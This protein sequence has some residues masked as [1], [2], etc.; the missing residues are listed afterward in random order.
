MY[1]S[2][3]IFLMASLQVSFKSGLRLGIK[4]FSKQYYANLRLLRVF[5]LRLSAKIGGL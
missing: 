3:S 5:S 1:K 4:G 2:L